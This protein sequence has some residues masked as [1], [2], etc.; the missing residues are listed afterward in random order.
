MTGAP[1][2]HETVPG[3]TAALGVWVRAAQPTSQR[4]WRVCAP[5]GRSFCDDAVSAPL[6]YC[7]ADRLARWLGGRVHAGGLRRDARPRSASRRR[8]LVL[9]TVSQPVVRAD[10]PSS[11]ARRQGFD[12]VQDSPAE[13][14]AE[15]ALQA[16][17]ADHPLGPAGAGSSRGVERRRCPTWCGFTVLASGLATAGG[18]GAAWRTAAGAHGS[19]A[20]ATKAGRVTTSR[21]GAQ[22]CWPKSA[23][24]SSSVR[25]PVLPGYPLTAEIYTLGVLHQLLGGGASSRLFREMRDLMGLVYDLDRGLRGA[26]A[27]VLEIMFSP[28]PPGLMLRCS[29]CLGRVGAGR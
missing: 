28:R 3:A 18:G 29:G 12:L 8:E 1:V 23:T 17:W 14:M 2:T 7:R 25:Q 9:E 11:S 22:G 5:A 16:C 20:A 19:G 27:G 10:E 13:V 15:L 4:I 21:L 6:R 26:P 24:G